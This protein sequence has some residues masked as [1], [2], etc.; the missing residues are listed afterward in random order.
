MQNTRKSLVAA[1]LVLSSAVAAHAAARPVHVA[2][3]VAHPAVERIASG[4][5]E[6]LN[7]KNHTLIL[8]HRTY[9][10][11]PALASASVKPGESVKVFYKEARGHR[12]VSKIIASS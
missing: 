8:G 11:S 1:A 5:I 3:P 12:M 4:K 10:F 7:V 6:R 9:R 2:K